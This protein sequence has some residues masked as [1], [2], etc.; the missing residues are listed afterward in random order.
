[1]AEKLNRNVMAMATY[2]LARDNGMGHARAV[3]EAK[4][5]IQQTMYEYA[6]WNRPVALRGKKAA[7]FLFM[8]YV[9][10]TADFATQ[11][12]KAALRFWLM[13]GLT[14]GLMGLPFAEDAEDMIDFIATKLNTWLG[15]KNPKFNLRQEL[16][17][18]LTELSV[19][20]DLILHGFGQ[21]SFG[22]KG[23]SELFGIPMPSID[24]SSSLGIGNIIPGTGIPEAMTRGID[25]AL[26]E[27]VREGGGALGSTFES[28]LNSALSDDPNEWKRF[29]KWMPTFMKNASQ[30]ARMWK[31]Q[32]VETA[33]GQTVADF[34]PMDPRS[35][36]EIGMKALGFQPTRVSRGWERVMA[37][38]EYVEFY[39]MMQAQR[40]KVMNA[41]LFVKDREAIADAR[42]SIDQFNAMVPYPE[43]KID[44]DII[45][46][47]FEQYMERR[48][49]SSKGFTD[50]EKN[51]RMQREIRE[52]YKNP[53]DA[54][55]LGN[56]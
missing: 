8:N 31:E 11:G 38:K 5:A 51:L 26:R 33:S 25:P 22:L 29:E 56:E 37:E 14:S 9:V 17:E 55:T 54:G 35:S 36:I 10:N 52:G 1:V 24:M 34:D 40:L 32:K 20:P 39:R 23:L 6:S 49:K 7:L 47:S 41:A 16:R 48:M 18:Y 53:G 2:N 44:A 12:N 28:M 30:A 46:Q 3:E 15:I 42:K 13:M 19:N 21:Q 50:G 45:Q 4:A 27:V 43:M